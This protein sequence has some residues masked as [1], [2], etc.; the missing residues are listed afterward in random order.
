M[1]QACAFGSRPVQMTY[2]ADDLDC[3]EVSVGQ[4]LHYLLVDLAY[5]GKSTTQILQGLQSAFPFPQSDE[6]RAAHRLFGEFNLGIVGRA[7]EA[8]KLG[9]AEALGVLMIEAQEE[10]R[11]KNIVVFAPRT[12]NHIP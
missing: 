9:D 4:P 12:L 6:H 5:P 7:V 8:L 11:R 2:D 1:D 10:V 3:V